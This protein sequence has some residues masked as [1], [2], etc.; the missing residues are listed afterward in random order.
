MLDLIIAGVL[1]LNPETEIETETE[2]VATRQT[3]EQTSTQVSTEVESEYVYTLGEADTYSSTS[4]TAG[5]VVII[6][7][8]N[9]RTQRVVQ[10]GVQYDPEQSG[11]DH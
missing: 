8:V 5:E 2:A 9:G 1:T 10:Q 3:A 6:T 7:V 4:E 11:L